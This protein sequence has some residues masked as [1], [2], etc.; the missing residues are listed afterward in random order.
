MN[1]KT[2]PEKLVLDFFERVWSP[3]HDL[4]AIDE[5]MT[6]D[7]TI[8]SAGSTISGRQAFKSWIREFH[9]RL[10]EAKTESIDVFSNADQ[11]K[12][13]SRWVCSGYNHG[14]LGLPKDD[15]YVTFT[16]IAI[17]RV[18]ENRLAEC[19]V[20]RSAWELYQQLT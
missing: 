10:N 7:Y 13:V 2:Q 5:I 9:E 4:E 8:H 14:I 1:I 6:E 3:P 12:V 15:R 18:R 16:G 19:W 11:S 17:W 20:E